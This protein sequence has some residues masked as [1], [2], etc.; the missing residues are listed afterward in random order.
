[1]NAGGCRAG[2]PVQPAPEHLVR[3]Q[4]HEREGDQR[5][6][7]R[8]PPRQARGARADEQEHGAARA[9]QQPER[10]GGPD[11]LEQQQARHE[12]AR[13]AAEDVRRLQHPDLAAAGRGIVLDRALQRA[14]RKPH[15]ERRQAEERERQQAVEPRECRQRPVRAEVEERLVPPVVEE[16]AVGR[17]CGR[18]PRDERERQAGAGEQQQL[19]IE[20]R[21]ERALEA[22][23]AAAADQA[24][25]AEAEEVEGE[26]GAEGVGRA[27][28]G[29]VHQP[30]PRDLER[31][32]DEAREPVEQQPRPQRPRGPV[33]DGRA[34]RGALGPEPHVGTCHG[35]HRQRGHQVAESAHAHRA[36]HAE[37]AH[38]HP[39]REQRSRRRAEHVQPVEGADHARGARGLPHRGPDQE[40]Q[41][42]PHECRRQQEGEEV[43]ERGPGGRLVERGGVSAQAVV[44]EPAAEHGESAHGELDEPEGTRR[45]QPT[46]PRAQQP[47]ELAADPEPGH[48]R[49]DD[50][51][52][53]HD[54]DAG[55]Q[56]QDPLPHHLVDERGGAAQ[57]EGEAEE[58]GQG[59]RR[60]R[61][62]RTRRR[63]SRRA[64]RSAGAP[65]AAAAA[66]RARR[67]SRTSRG[68]WRARRSG[69]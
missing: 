44:V 31:E 21:H 66:R 29:D 20:E 69:C 3:G 2:D 51:R 54:A 49:R 68:C 35:E 12:A 55:V 63:R 17:R 30:E 53:R 9:Q 59:A 24:A 52:H 22:G 26:H 18:Q 4:G 62:R 34:L 14:E 60:F 19:E 10:P 16:E 65:S 47:S 15:H 39:R 5:D 37:K 33:G 40:R 43:C 6:A 42:H 11:A 32:R 45:R 8:E 61:A 46:E 7:Q 38:Q 56:R 41:R 23:G 36:L 28:H 64:P 48:E 13:R 1:M 25:Q 58:R 27:L 50:E 67:S 57:E